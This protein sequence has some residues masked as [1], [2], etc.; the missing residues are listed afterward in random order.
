MGGVE[1]THTDHGTIDLLQNVGDADH[2]VVFVGNQQLGSL[3]KTVL[4]VFLDFG[5]IRGIDK[6]FLRQLL[7]GEDRERVDDQTDNG[8]D[9]SHGAPCFGS[10]TQCGDGQQR[11]RLDCKAGGEREHEA[12]GTHLNTL[13]AVLGDKGSQ[14]RVRAHQPQP[15]CPRLPGGRHHH[16]AV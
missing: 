6:L 9:D 12:V 15:E 8:V 3:D 13:G 10:V 4:L 5:F 1:G 2:Q 7:D 11:E 16:H 14:G